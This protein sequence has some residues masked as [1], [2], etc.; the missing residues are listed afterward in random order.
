MQCLLIDFL[1]NAIWLVA[2]ATCI[3]RQSRLLHQSHT[4]IIVIKHNQCIVLLLSI[5]PYDSSFRSRDG[6]S[7]PAGISL[8]TL[9]WSSSHLLALARLLGR[10]SAPEEPRRGAGRSGGGGGLGGGA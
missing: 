6:G 3:P 5:I 9:G 2:D 8:I 10:P 1:W 4:W 7:S